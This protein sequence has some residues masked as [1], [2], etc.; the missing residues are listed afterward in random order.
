MFNNAFFVTFNTFKLKADVKQKGQSGFRG[1]GIAEIYLSQR[2]S[3]ILTAD[4]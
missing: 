2:R 4:H 1:Q 3:E